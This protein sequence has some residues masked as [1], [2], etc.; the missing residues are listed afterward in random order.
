MKQTALPVIGQ[1]IKKLKFYF[2]NPFEGQVKAFLAFCVW[3][4]LDFS[5]K[6]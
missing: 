1:G 3:L 5:R 2:L 6:T 4:S